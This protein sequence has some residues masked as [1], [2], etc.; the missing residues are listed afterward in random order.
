MSAE[1]SAEQATGRRS[2]LRRSAAA[3]I[4]LGPAAAVVAAAAPADAATRVPGAGV[5]SLRATSAA[6]AAS[7]TVLQRGQ[8]AYATDT[9]VVKVGDGVHR[10]SRL[11]GFVD[12]AH[13][14]EAVA[15][16]LGAAIVVSPTAPASPTRF[17]L[18][19]VWIDASTLATPVPA[20]PAVPVFD[21]A[22]SAYTIPAGVVGV[23]Y[24]VDGKVL[25]QGATYAVATVPSTV[26]VTATAQ[27]G[28]SLIGD[29]VFGHDFPDPAAMVTLTSDSFTGTGLLDL[30]GRTT[31]A[32]LG[33]VGLAWVAGAGNGIGAA[34]P[35]GRRLV[36]G[37]Q[38]GASCRLAYPGVHNF[39]VDLDLLAIADNGRPNDTMLAVELLGRGVSVQLGQHRTR[40]QCADHSGGALDLQFGL[41]TPSPLGHWKLRMVGNTFSISD[42]AG[43]VRQWYLDPATYDVGAPDAGAAVSIRNNACLANGFSWALGNL[44]VT[45]VGF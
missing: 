2:L 5:I 31:D 9:H 29:Y 15:R 10:W 45:K 41:N 13:L 37:L 20:Q 44:A 28:Y 35:G 11:P 12:E 19:V 22:R 1:M 32:A 23:D 17:G 4:G 21:D 24:V 6:L 30:V 16:V 40:I 7:R 33:G 39:Q 14:E 38:Q 27:D 26:T 8:L 25:E 36:N 18:P 3:A 43:A 34:V 42:G